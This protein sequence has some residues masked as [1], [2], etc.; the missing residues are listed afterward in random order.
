LSLQIHMTIGYGEYASVPTIECP[1]AITI[2]AFQCIIA[3]VMSAILF[4]TYQ[5]Q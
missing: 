2:V 4:G 3:L 1:I 5:P